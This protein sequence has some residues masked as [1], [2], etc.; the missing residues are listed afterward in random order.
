MDT[1]LGQHNSAFRYPVKRLKCSNGALTRLQPLSKSRFALLDAHLF[2]VDGVTIDTN[3]GQ[4]V[5]FY[6]AEQ[7]L[8]PLAHRGTEIVS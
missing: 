3:D 4:T 5:L 2:N 7:P 8:P 6:K 1:I